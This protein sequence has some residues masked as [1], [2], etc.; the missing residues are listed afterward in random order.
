MALSRFK[1][2]AIKTA[3][4]TTTLNGSF[5]ITIIVPQRIITTQA[6]NTRD[7]RAP[8]IQNKHKFL[9]KSPM[10][11]MSSEFNVYDKVI[12]YVRSSCAILS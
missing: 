8:R 7:D 10:K 9:I 2:K 3:K 5:N 12:F 11:L 4:W 1:E 6:R